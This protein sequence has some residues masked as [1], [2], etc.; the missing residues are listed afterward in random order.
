MKIV[1][2]TTQ[3][4]CD[5]GACTNGAEYR[6]VRADTLL[7]NSLNLC[8]F[9]T[10]ELHTLFGTVLA[11]KAVENLIKK[12]QKKTKELGERKDEKQNG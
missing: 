2:I 10:K 12:A 9:C 3:T 6:I 11:P 8:P 7:T 5:N 4:V 1:K